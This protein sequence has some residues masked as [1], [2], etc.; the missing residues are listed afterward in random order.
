MDRYIC[1]AKRVDNDE[2]VYGYYVSASH[3][4]HSEHLIIKQ[5]T[6]YDGGGEFW[7]M[8]VH[9]VDPDTVCRYIGKEDKCGT[10]IFE[11]DICEVN[12]PYGPFDENGGYRFETWTA[13]CEF[14]Q[15]SAEFICINQYG[16]IYRWYGTD[17]YSDDKDEN[18][19]VIGN[20]FDS[21]ELLEVT[22]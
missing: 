12:M 3:F 5:D 22:E 4:G 19:E 2:W 16:D 1:R 15:F 18:V 14:N 21:P 20:K 8:N 9:E 13:I 6:Q 11:S 10:P 7:Y 17:G